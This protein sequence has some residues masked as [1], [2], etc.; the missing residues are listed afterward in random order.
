MNKL[1]AAELRAKVIKD[2]A[3]SSAKD[4]PLAAMLRRTY[5]FHPGV[6]KD[7]TYRK[8]FTEEFAAIEAEI[9]E[10]G[11]AAVYK[12]VYAECL[13]DDSLRKSLKK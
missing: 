13:K 6:R 10:K 8:A 1:T 9:N 2:H 4:I 7:A 11:H 5:M 12:E 3:E